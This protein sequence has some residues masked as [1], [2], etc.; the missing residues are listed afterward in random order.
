MRT[1]WQLCHG[2]TVSNHSVLN[3][4]PDCWTVEEWWIVVVWI[5]SVFLFGWKGRTTVS[6]LCGLPPLLS[7]CCLTKEVKDLGL[8]EPLSRGRIW[9][10]DQLTAQH[11]E[12]LVCEYSCGFKAACIRR[13]LLCHLYVMRSRKL[14]VNINTLDYLFVN[15]LSFL[16]PQII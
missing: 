3:D 16:T 5:Y 6:H 4:R 7:S 10:S 14:S 8:L 11:C 1:W 15:P 9:A 12:V 13:H 2:L